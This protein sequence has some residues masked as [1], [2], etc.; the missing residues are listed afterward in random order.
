MNIKIIRL[1]VISLIVLFSVV[2]GIG[3][4]FP[5]TV[6]VSRAVTVNAGYDS[7]Y[8]YL[9][10]VKYWKLWMAGADSSTIEFLSA[11]TAGMGT[12]AKIGTGQITITRNTPD[13]IYS[14]WKSEQGNVQT[15]AFTIIR[16]SAN[17]KTVVQWYFEQ[18]L[19]W[20]PWERF[21]SFANDKILG[22]VM[23]QSFDKLKRVIERSGN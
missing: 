23:E 1:I 21:G 16:D 11:R 13:S 3:L 22:P 4:L 5:S 20:Y 7:V 12:V 9:N 10:D 6:R 2:T 19:N 14:T 18:K 15:S 17:T 8:K